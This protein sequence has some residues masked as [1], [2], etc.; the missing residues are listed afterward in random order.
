M[1]MGIFEVFGFATP[2]AV[3][4]SLFVSSF[5]VFLVV[6]LGLFLKR[7]KKRPEIKAKRA[8]SRLDAW[9]NQK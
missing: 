5:T 6:L 4:L 3:I 8:K 1:S 9:L 2:S 7:Q